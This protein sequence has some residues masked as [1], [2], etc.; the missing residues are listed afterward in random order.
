MGWCSLDE[1]VI[2]CGTH[3]DPLDPIQI[4]VMDCETHIADQVQ[5]SL[6]DCV[7]VS[8]KRIL[9]LKE[10]FEVYHIG[11]VSVVSVG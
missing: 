7:C 6:V 11:L 8:F 9:S 2:L 10:S 5:D 4:L 1:S 3:F